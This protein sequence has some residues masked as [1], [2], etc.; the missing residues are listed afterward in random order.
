MGTLYGSRNPGC[1]RTQFVVIWSISVIL[2]HVNHF[3]YKNHDAGLKS[4]PHLGQIVR[5]KSYIIDCFSFLSLK[6]VDGFWLLRNSRIAWPLSLSR[7]KKKKKPFAYL[8]A[9]FQKNG[10]GNEL[11]RMSFILMTWKA[12]LGRIFNNKV[13]LS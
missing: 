3:N 13:S 1:T 10:N 6:K 5:H 12:R 4:W 11:P 7:K 9:N 2:L 8:L